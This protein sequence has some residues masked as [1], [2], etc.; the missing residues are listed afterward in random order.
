MWSWEDMPGVVSDEYGDA[1]TQLRSQVAM[2]VTV[3]SL[4][5]AVMHRKGSSSLIRILPLKPPSHLH[6]HEGW[7]RI[8]P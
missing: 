8:G 1:E 7:H 2:A 6:W 3:V 4:T 5:S